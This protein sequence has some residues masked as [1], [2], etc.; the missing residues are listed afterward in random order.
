MG[1]INSILDRVGVVLILINGRIISGDFDESLNEFYLQTV[2]TFSTESVL[3]KNQLTDL[4]NYLKKHE[5]ES[6]GQVITLYDQMPVLLSKAEIEKLL[7]DLEK[8]LSMYD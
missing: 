8:V 1:K 2:K 3:K 6:G 4:Y 5:D 7:Q